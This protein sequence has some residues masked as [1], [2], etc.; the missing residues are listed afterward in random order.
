MA[1][2]RW[3][4]FLD[5]GP[6]ESV[7]SK[8]SHA[9]FAGITVP[10]RIGVNSELYLYLSHVHKSCPGIPTNKPEKKKKNKNC[11]TKR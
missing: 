10:N 11:L 3:D 2:K 1:H 7:R 6:G 5:P 9:F 4:I 8:A